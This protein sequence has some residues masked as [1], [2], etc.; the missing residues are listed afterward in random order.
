M[1]GKQKA[2]RM[3]VQ[4]RLERDCRSWGIEQKERESAFPKV[5]SEEY[6]QINGSCAN[7]ASLRF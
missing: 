4:V 3:G 6:H 7:N 5:C 1:R 2:E